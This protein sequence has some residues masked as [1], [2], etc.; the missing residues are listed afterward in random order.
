MFNQFISI[1]NLVIIVRY[2]YFEHVK[3]KISIVPNISEWST[4]TTKKYFY[5]NA[6]LTVFSDID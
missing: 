6:V 5:R 1:Y 3:L 2:R 4:W